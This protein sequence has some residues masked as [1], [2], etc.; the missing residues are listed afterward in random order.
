MLTLNPD[1]R[2]SSARLRQRQPLLRERVCVSRSVICFGCASDE[3]HAGA[4]LDNVLDL[5]RKLLPVAAPCVPGAASA[6]E[7]I[8][9]VAALIKHIQQRTGKTTDQILADAQVNLDDTD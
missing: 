1:I 3:N 6:P 2:P 7:I 8:A 9:S 4:I 5:L